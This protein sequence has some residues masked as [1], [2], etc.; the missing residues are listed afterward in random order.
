M[1]VLSVWTGY[2]RTDTIGNHQRVSS[3]DAP[4]V[5]LNGDQGQRMAVIARPG[6]GDLAMTTLS[7]A[8]PRRKAS[9]GRASVQPTATEPM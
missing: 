6:E 1:A 2:R 9:I 4:D 7:V 3:V 5:V 8:E